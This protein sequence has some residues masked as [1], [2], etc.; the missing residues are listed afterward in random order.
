MLDSPFFAQR[1]L[2]RVL[3]D[4]PDAGDDLFG[5]DAEEPDLFA[6]EADEV[7]APQPPAQAESDDA[8]ADLTAL[9]QQREREL[10]T[11][12]RSKLVRWPDALSFGPDGYLYLA[13]SALP[14]VILQS[15]EHIRAAGPYRIF[16]FQPGFDGVPGQ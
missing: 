15:R 12:M 3:A 7:D 14:D 2:L 16:R 9:V 4:E 13:D 5:E 11:L 1:Q 8:L 6:D 10:E